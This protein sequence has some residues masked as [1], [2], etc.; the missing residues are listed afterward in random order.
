[1]TL[2]FS[3]GSDIL[4]DKIGSGPIRDNRL[5][6]SYLTAE[7]Y[8]KM[9]EIMQKCVDNIPNAKEYEN[10]R[11]S[12]HRSPFYPLYR[13]CIE[14]NEAAKERGKPDDRCVICGCLK[15][16][17]KGVIC[18]QCR[19]SIRQ[20]HSIRSNTCSYNDDEEFTDNRLDSS[21]LTA[22]EFIRL[23][24]LL[25]DCAEKMPTDSG[26]PRYWLSN[27]RH[28]LH[29]VYEYCVEL[30]DAAI[31]RGM[32]EDR[33]PICGHKKSKAYMRSPYCY[34]CNVSISQRFKIRGKA[35][36]SVNGVTHTSLLQKYKID[37]Y[38]NLENN[39]HESDDYRFPESFLS[40][41]DYKNL[42]ALLQKCCEENKDKPH[43][44]RGSK[45][46]DADHPLRR[47]YVRC[48]ELRKAA[49]EVGMPDDKCLICGSDLDRDKKSEY[50]YCPTCSRFI[51]QNHKIR[52]RTT[53]RN[54]NENKL[55]VVCHKRPA[56]KNM[57]GMC[58]AC[59]RI[60]DRL[61]D[62]S[63]EAIRAKRRHRDKI[64]IQQGINISHVDD[65]LEPSGSEKSGFTR[66]IWNL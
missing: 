19:D 11:I 13:Y 61:G 28:P 51:L 22:D 64:D 59:Y 34:N 1:M 23:S 57:G 56:A 42:Q 12:F 50:P 24:K 54:I 21:Y 55:C 7:E 25:H 62:H 17:E 49:M 6:G 46:Q 20:E 33:C 29:P 32:P 9:C 18:R 27:V 40:Y 10:S 43:P 26:R 37:L 48:V 31:A 53:R 3:L 44:T 45:I 4:A 63:V 36:R 58:R 2:F 15:V 14:V 52:D 38:G 16:S 47:V 60:G 30:K 41:E 8:V 35:T 5:R 66:K 39:D 65:I